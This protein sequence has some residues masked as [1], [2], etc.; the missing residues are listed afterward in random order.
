MEKHNS[1]PL[2]EGRGSGYIREEREGEDE[3]Q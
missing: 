3:Q 2:L 1:Y